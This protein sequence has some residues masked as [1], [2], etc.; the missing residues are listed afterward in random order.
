MLS[1]AFKQAFKRA[2]T[3]NT[4]QTKTISEY[5]KKCRIFIKVQNI[6]KKCRICDFRIF[7]IC[8]E[9]NVK[10]SRFH[11]ISGEGIVN[12]EIKNVKH[13]LNASEDIDDWKPKLRCK[14]P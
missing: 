4:T 7:K 3:E 12:H 2:D 10:L 8:A 13:N 11:A 6:E 9:R 14:L 1:N 5:L